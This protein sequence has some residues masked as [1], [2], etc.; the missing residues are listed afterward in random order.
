MSSMRKTKH[1]FC[2]RTFAFYVLT[3]NE[4]TNIGTGAL[5]VMVGP[6]LHSATIAQLKIMSMTTVFNQTTG[7]FHKSLKL[8]LYRGQSQ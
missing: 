4:T 8:L 7:E 1:K 5:Y 3:K 6:M 2:T